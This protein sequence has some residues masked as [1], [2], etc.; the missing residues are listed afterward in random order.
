MVA[1][2]FIGAL[3][4]NSTGIAGALLIDVATFAASSLLYLTIVSAAPAR[5][6][7]EQPTTSDGPSRRDL[8]RVILA[9]P[10]VLGLTTSFTVVTAAMGLLNAALPVF[11]RTELGEPRAYGYALGAIGAGLMCGELMTGLV[12]RESV[13]RRSVGLAFASMAG[14][15]LIAAVTH[16]SAT[17]YLMLFL[18]G[19]C[20]GTTET[21]YDTLFQRRLPADVRAGVFAL[22]GSVQTAGMIVGLSLAPLV[23]STGGGAALRLSALG[24]AAGA[25]IATVSIATRRSRADSHVPVNSRTTG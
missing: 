25:V 7:E 14:C 4:V 18:I 16:S 13:A 6:E 3:V 5:V 11:F 2:A 1:G 22:A 20:D 15:L 19:A 12:T 9:N 17:A 21:T 10:I 23:A 8:V 24:C